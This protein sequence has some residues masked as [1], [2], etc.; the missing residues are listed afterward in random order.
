MPK[1]LMDHLGE[2]GQAVRGARRVRDDLVLRRVVLVV[3]DAEDDRQ[4]G[5]LGRRGD[6]DLLR[7]R[8]DVLGRVVALGEE[9]GRFEDD[10]DAEVLPGQLGRVAHREHLELVAVDRDGVFSRFDL[11]VQVAEHRVVLEQVRQRRRVGE[12]VHRDE[13]DVLVAERGAHDVAADAAEAIDANL[14]SHRTVTS[15]RRRRPAR[16]RTRQTS[17]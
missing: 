7:A 3:V 8:R 15:R 11:R 10:V 14:H 6:H 1:R 12:I 2:R 16:S 17:G 4:V 9:A 5:A 13:I